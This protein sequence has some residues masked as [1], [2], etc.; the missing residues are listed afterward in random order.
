VKATA[1]QLAEYY[2]KETSYRMKNAIEVIQ[3]SVSMIMMVVLTALTLVSSETA[4]VRPE[5]PHM[6]LPIHFLFP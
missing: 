6:L 2:E 4:L 1:L 3:L 5:N